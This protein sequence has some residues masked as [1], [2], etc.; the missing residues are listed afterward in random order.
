MELPVTVISPAGLEIVNAG[1]MHEG[2]LLGGLCG[3]QVDNIS[4][5]SCFE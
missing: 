1:V 4:E 2:Y 3:C 5:S